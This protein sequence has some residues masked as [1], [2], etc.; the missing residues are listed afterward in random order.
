[1]CHVH[2]AAMGVWLQLRLA[3]LLAAGRGDLSPARQGH[4]CLRVLRVQFHALRPG[5]L[6]GVAQVKGQGWPWMIGSAA[7]GPA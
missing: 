3:L 5:E 6:P 2:L 1:M 7:D 4:L